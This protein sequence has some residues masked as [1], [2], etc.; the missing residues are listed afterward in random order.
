MFMDYPKSVKGYHLWCL[1]PQFNKSI[2]NWD[3][4]FNEV[5]MTYRSRV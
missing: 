4:I 5:E 3:I 1:E 2:I